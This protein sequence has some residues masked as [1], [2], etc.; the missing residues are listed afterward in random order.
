MLGQP[1]KSESIYALSYV[2]KMSY[3]KR[4]ITFFA[5]YYL[6]EAPFTSFNA[7]AG[8]RTSEETATT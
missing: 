4:S 8:S 3:L 6:A 5:Q 1:G 7:T 2:D